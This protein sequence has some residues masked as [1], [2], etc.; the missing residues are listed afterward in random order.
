MMY[1]PR[2]FAH[3]ILTLEPD[4]EAIYCVCAHY[5]PAEERGVRWNDPRFGVEWPI[6]P[7]RRFRRRTPTGRISIR[8]HGVSC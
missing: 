8:L 1:V 6:A 4:T 7:R 2:G 5:A 3:A